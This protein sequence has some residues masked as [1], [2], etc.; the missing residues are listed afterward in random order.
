[1]AWTPLLLMLL[2]QCIGSLSQPGLIQ[3]PSLSA[4]SGKIARL[5]CTLSDG[6]SLENY[7]IS[8]YQ[9]KPG[10]S[11]QYLL[12]YYTDFDKNQGSGVPSRFSGS[13]DESG[14]AGILLISGLQP[15]DEAEYYCATAHGSGSSFR[16]PQCF[17]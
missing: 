1:M 4:S 10:N 3:P 5:T 16:F 15:E 8:L 17:R 14:N 2:F 9:Q 12:Y 11:L 13:N 7:G 6:F